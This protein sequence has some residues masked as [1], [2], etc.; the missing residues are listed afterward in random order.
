LEFLDL[1]LIHW[2]A[3]LKPGKYEF[4]FPKEDLLPMDFNS[5]WE[6]MEE[7]QKLG[8]AKHIGV[9]NFSCKKLETMLSTAKIPP[10]INQVSFTNYSSLMKRAVIYNEIKCMCN[11]CFGTQGGD[12]PSLAAEKAEGVL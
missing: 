3:S 12:E 4:P 9:S 10:A 5:V 7:C 2:P 8:L 1:Y 6:A 11:I